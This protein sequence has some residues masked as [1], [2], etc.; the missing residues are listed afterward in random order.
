MKLG[1]LSYE[2]GLKLQNFVAKNHILGSGDLNTILLLEH[3]PVYTVGLRT[4]NYDKNIEN[5][6]RTLGTE[7]YRTNRGG[8]I[9][10]HG[11]GQLVAYPILNLKD[12]KLTMK[13]YIVSLE[14]S[15]ISLCN[16]LNLKAYT[17]EHTGVWINDRKVCAIGVHGSRYITT[18]GLALNCSIDVLKGFEHIIPCGIEGK[19]VTSLSKELKKSYSVNE[20]ADA[21]LNFFCDTFNCTY[22]HMPKEENDNLLTD[23]SLNNNKISFLSWV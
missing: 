15:I 20:A 13:S 5:K 17:C 10:Y 11:P 23:L 8:L 4:A 9:T 7:F 2:A 3:T 18:H 6:L 12:F 22:I 19:G 16:S 21:F 14:K 1:T